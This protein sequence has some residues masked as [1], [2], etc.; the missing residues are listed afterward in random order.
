M[1]TRAIVEIK[2]TYAFI[3]R[4]FLLLKAY[5]LWEV[6][7]LIYSMC[8][9]LSIGFLGKGVGEKLTGGASLNTNDL[10]LFLL[11]GSLLWSFLS[12][13]FWNVSNAI[14]WERWEGTIEYTFMAPVSRVTHLA[15]MC[16]FA[17]IYATL[18]MIVMLGIVALFFHVDLSRANF[19]S[20]IVILAS[21][22][23]SFVG[24]GMAAAVLPLL[25]QEKGAQITGIIE[26]VLLMVSGVY[27][28]VSV[29]PSWLQA[30][31]KVSPATYVLS[32]M[33]SAL[34]N[35]ASVADLWPSILKL[36]IIGAILLPL[37]LK[38]FE[39]GEHHCKKTGKL[40]R[41]G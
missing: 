16:A 41:M 10:I 29:L 38:I 4:Q 40:K 12:E 1:Q 36:L 9:T 2:A 39:I 20:A 13:L 24:L 25:S 21:A 11:T 8:M 19:S 23:F 3:E 32:G 14:T 34:L 31:S 22:S 5:W 17:I 15:G 33:R 30:A 37:G 18:K 26:G 6:V 27:Y 7:W 28:E 35:D